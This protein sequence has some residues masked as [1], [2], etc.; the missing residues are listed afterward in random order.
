MITEHRVLQNVGWRYDGGVT[1]IAE[2]VRIAD[3]AGNP[4]G[5]VAAGERVV[6]RPEIGRAAVN[7]K[8]ARARRQIAYA[9]ARITE[10]IQRRM[11][12]RAWSEL[13][14]SGG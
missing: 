2:T 7:R 5:G 14:E 8:I 6:V 12:V 1:Q 10:Q 9:V 3:E 13:S 11:D 4:I